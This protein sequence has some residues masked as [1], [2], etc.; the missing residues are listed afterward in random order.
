MRIKLAL[1]ALAVVLLAASPSQLNAQSTPNSVGPTNE[2]GVQP[3]GPY[4]GAHEDINLGNGNLN[5]QIPLLSLPGRNGHNFSL[6][7]HYD[8]KIWEPSS[9]YESDTGQTIYYWTAQAGSIADGWSFNLPYLIATLVQPYQ[10]NP[11]YYCYGNYIFVS[12]DGSKHAFSLP[13]AP[14]NGVKTDC[15]LQTN[16]GQTPEPSVDTPTGTAVDASFYFLDTTNPSN[17]LVRAKDGTTYHFS[18]Y[19]GGTPSTIEDTN[20]NQINIST[21][22]YPQ[23]TDSV[24]R[25]VSTTR[26]SSSWSISYKDSAG[27]Q[28]TV[29]LSFTTTTLTPTF[30]LPANSS[31]GPVPYSLLLNSVTL[32]SGLSWTFQY[33]NYAELTKVTYPTG[34]YTRY[35]YTADTNWFQTPANFNVNPSFAADFREVSARY[36]CRLASGSCSP[37]TTPEDETTY[38]PTVDGTKTNNEFMDVVSPLGDR[39]RHQFS[40][41]TSSSANSNIY[42]MRETFRYYY[43]GQSTLLRTVETDYNNLDSNGNTTSYSLP[44]RETTTLSDVTPNLIKKTEWDYTGIIDQ[45]SEERD[46][47]WGSGAFGALI[48]K[49]DYTWLGT[50]SVNGQNY[51]STSI[52]ILNRKTLEQINT[53]SGTTIAQT[54]YEYDNYASDSK[55][56]PLV[57]SG[58][59]QHDSSFSTTYTTRGNVTAV[60]HWR[61][62]DGSWLT[63]YSQLDDAGNLLASID[64]LNNQTSFGFTDSW[65]NAS[66]APSGQAKA[67]VTKITNALGQSTTKTYNSCSGLL[68]STT[69]P[70]LLTTSPTYDLMGRAVAVAFPDGGNRTDCFSDLGGTG[71]SQSPVPLVHVA[72]KSINASVNQTTTSVLD[73]LGRTTE[74]QLNSDPQGAVLVDTT[75]DSLERVATVSNPYRNGT[76]PTSSP[77]ITTFIYDPLGRK[78]V[79]VPADGTAVS[80]STCPTAAPAKDVFTSYAGNCTTVTDPTGRSRKSC[81]DGLGR[82]TTVI[83]DPAGLGYATTYSYDVLGDLAQVVQNGSH[84]RTFTYNS[85]AQLLTST[86]PEAGTITYTYDADGNVATKMDARSIITTYHYDAL[87]RQ[88]SRSYSNSDP[89]VTTTYDQSNC[90]GLSACQN[91]GHATSVTD[92]AGSEAWSY[93]TDK[94]NNRSIHVNQRTTNS[95]PSNI[96]KTSTYYFD[97]SGNLT[98]ITYPTGRIVNYTYDAASRPA[99]AV[100]SANGVTYATAR[101]TPP[102][103]CLTTGVCYTPQGTE[104]SAAVGVTSSFTGINYSETYNNRLQPLEIKAGP[105]SGNVIDLTYSFADPITLGNAGHVSSITNNLNSSRSQAFAHDSLNRITTAGTTA[106]SGTYCWGYQYSYDAWG[107]LLSQAGWSP[108]YNG[109]TETTMGAVTANGS[110]QISGFSYDASGNAQSDGT[111]SYTWN[112]ESQMKTAAGVTYA[113]DG[114][115]RRASKVGSKLYWYGSGGEILAET[116]ASGNTLNEY[117]FFGGKRIAML[118]AGG[119]AQYYVE[120]LLGSSRVMTTNTGTLCYDADFDPYGGEHPYTNNCSSNNNYKFEGK[121]RDTETG[122]DDF[123]ARYYSNRFGRWLSADWSSVPAPVPCANLSNPQTLNLYAMVSDDP[124]SFAD[125]DGHEGIGGFHNAYSGDQRTIELGGGGLSPLDATEGWTFVVNGTLTYITDYDEAS[126]YYAQAVAQQQAQNQSGSQQT[127]SDKR[128]DVMLSATSVPPKPSTTEGAQFEMDYKI[129]PQANT[130]QQLQDN[131]SRLQNDSETQAS[132][133]KMEVKLWE[134]Q[135]GEKWQWQGDALNGHGHDVLNVFA[136]SAD[137]RWYVDGKRVQMVIGKDSTGALIKAWTVHVEVKSAGPVFSKVD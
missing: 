50:N 69:D 98:S 17:V 76:D 104:Y 44:I 30:Q 10:R 111:Y 106:T 40:Y 114:D 77:G 86:N 91:I 32:P 136:K 107:N 84:Q 61:N 21:G 38:T 5:L 65:S 3:Y 88:T 83:E 124:E 117:I 89:S 33:N 125:L 108:T 126:A 59:V 97:L 24:G 71:C 96:T 113:Y 72:S 16:Q 74:T 58:A 25:L 123:G 52:Y 64:P 63:T 56:A 8:S 37:S 85:L 1:Y 62:T 9:E 105:S 45:V 36:V 15:Y 42:S 127:A 112:A 82:L 119:S 20:G 49:K 94:T 35:A 19:T 60:E 133:S 87:N 93:Q 116:D 137:Q 46:F 128:T 100:D 75:Y 132:Y 135:R 22:I 43:Q 67:Y 66:C 31:P 95:S 48:R 27:T 29:T 57:A 14:V 11:N 51:G 23:I 12:S 90:L 53:A 129:V 68:A 81:S 47:D 73:G 7:L 28:R 134:S 34:G 121:E 2:T 109:C 78:C 103:G 101:G 79:E 118:P 54:Q 131:Y 70:N 80:G 99:T 4:G 110:N 18:S 115:G 6:S 13:T 41:L 130:M 120:D 55:H 39:T 122:N 26:G 102:T 92:A